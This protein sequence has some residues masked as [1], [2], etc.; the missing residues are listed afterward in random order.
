MHAPRA[1]TKSTLPHPP[2]RPPLSTPRDSPPLPVPLRARASVST[3][4]APHT[5]R[6]SPRARSSWAPHATLQGAGQHCPAPYL[7]ALHPSSTH[8]PRTRQQA[9]ARGA[10]TQTSRSKGADAATLPHHPNQARQHQESAN[11]PSEHNSSANT[12]PQPPT[13][14]ANT[15][16]NKPCCHPRANTGHAH[17]TARGRGSVNAGTRGSRATGTSETRRNPQKRAR[18]Q[19]TQG[20]RKQRG[21]RR[22]PPCARPTGGEP[23]AKA[24]HA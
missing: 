19:R 22:V 10:H 5:P 14:R 12:K 17:A 24:G 15:P 21:S 11:T 7:A 18:R 13:Q 4:Q 16:T 8:K 20:A 1:R 2:P 3:L 23:R 9:H 6:L